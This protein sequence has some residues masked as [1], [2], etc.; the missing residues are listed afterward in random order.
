MD[1]STKT[2][3][4]SLL[5]ALWLLLTLFGCGQTPDAPEPPSQPPSQQELSQEETLSPL[6]EVLRRFPHRLRL[7]ENI[8]NIYPVQG[9]PEAL[10]YY[11]ESGELGYWDVEAGRGCRLSESYPSW[12]LTAGMV[13]PGVL[14]IISREGITRWELGDPVTVIKEEALVAPL[15]EEKRFDFSYNFQRDQLFWVDTAR[16]DLRYGAWDSEGTVLWESTLGENT[17]PYPSI[18][19]EGHRVMARAG[20]P[21]F[22][23]SGR[24]AFFAEMSGSYQHRPV[25]YDLETGVYWAAEELTEAPAVVGCMIGE[26]GV[27]A[28][29]Y[30]ISGEAPQGWNKVTLVTMAGREEVEL[31]LTYHYCFPGETGLSLQDEDG[32]LY[33]WDLASRESEMIYRSEN[34]RVHISDVVS[35]SRFDAVLFVESFTNKWA[36]GILPREDAPEA[37]PSQPE[38]AAAATQ[39]SG[40]LDS[41]LSSCYRAPDVPVTDPLSMLGQGERVDEKKLIPIYATNTP[42]KEELLALCGKLESGERLHRLMQDDGI[43]YTVIT[44]GSGRETAYAMIDPSDLT[45]S[46]YGGLNEFTRREFRS[47][48][49]VEQLIAQG[50]LDSDKAEMAHC[51]ITGFAS[52]NLLWD[53]EQEY[54]IPSL[55]DY[56]VEITGLLTVGK[57]YTV[58]EIANI[59]RENIDTIFS[60]TGGIAVQ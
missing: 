10:L 39:Q 25:L 16:S 6:Q 56:H 28:C 20:A 19:E 29:D 37:D 13:E 41:I 53:G 17:G 2:C 11:T 8:T 5:L 46:E 58:P 23:D 27:L 43:W 48:E 32:D 15:P 45:V 52:G 1:K 22:S 18:D 4:L 7:N 38:S 60:F 14:Q 21:A 33:H 36:V 51:V 12:E 59:I 35:T 24:L 49:A 31:D 42:G 57:V 26:T 40:V 9:A 50:K 3:M 54:F 30:D 44:D 34:S 47:G 55:K